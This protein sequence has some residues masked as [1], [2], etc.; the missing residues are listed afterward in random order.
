MHTAYFVIIRCFLEDLGRQGVNCD[1]GE[2]V[3]H[4][5]YSKVLSVFTLAELISF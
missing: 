2:D 4:S 5:C 1:E 3:S